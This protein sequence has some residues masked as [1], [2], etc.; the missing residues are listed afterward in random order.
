MEALC[1]Q[2][3][4]DTKTD[5]LPAPN[6]TA[7]KWGSGVGI[8]AARRPFVRSDGEEEVMEN[9]FLI[10]GDCSHVQ[11]VRG[12]CHFLNKQEQENGYLFFFFPSTAVGTKNGKKGGGGGERGRGAPT[13]TFDKRKRCFYFCFD[14]KGFQWPPPSPAHCLRGR[15]HLGDP[16]WSLTTPPRTVLPP[17]G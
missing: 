5:Q 9:R 12:E 15:A 13:D 7:H 6:H 14:L 17:S 16:L 1:Y 10:L 8:Q 2:H 4:A 11:G 3:L